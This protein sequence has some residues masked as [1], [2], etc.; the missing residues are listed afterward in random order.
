MH[1]AKFE[2]N[3]IIG[4]LWVGILCVHVLKIPKETEYETE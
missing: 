4:V 2:K 3:M 1:K